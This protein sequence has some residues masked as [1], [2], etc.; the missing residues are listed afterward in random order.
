MIDVA[1]PLGVGG[2]PI[3]STP[4]AIMVPSAVLVIAVGVLVAAGVYLMLERSLT[5][6][7]LGFVLVGNGVNLLILLAGGQSAGPPIIGDDL[8][9]S[10]SD[11]LAQ[12]MVL[13][14]IVIT[15]ALVGFIA[16]IAYRSWQLNGHDEVQ[17]DVEDRRVA[18]HA[19]R[20][21]AAYS[22]ADAADSGWSLDEEAQEVR[23]DTDS[24][25]G[26][27]AATAGKMAAGRRER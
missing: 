3:A 12:A 18:L 9:A 8:T 16:A 17:D 1:A 26:D 24:G 4:P 5:R 6:I 11:P 7:L 19:A 2:P 14:S 27:V 13:T 20:N 23:D 21:E 10:M 22:D 15:L 25:E